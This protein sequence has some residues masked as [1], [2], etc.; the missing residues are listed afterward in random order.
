MSNDLLVHAPVLFSSSKALALQ[1]S[2]PLF[3][4]LKELFYKSQVF[5]FNRRLLALVSFRLEAA[6][7]FKLDDLQLQAEL[8]FPRLLELA[9]LLEHL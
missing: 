1:L 8:Q 9:A 7:H 6:H 2:H 3:A 4:T 5:A